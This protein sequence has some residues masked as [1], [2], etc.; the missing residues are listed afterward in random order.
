MS[1]VDCWS[2]S[3]CSYV[4]GLTHAKINHV[5]RFNRPYLHGFQVT[6]W[7]LILFL[8]KSS[9][10]VVFTSV[11]IS[12]DDT[13]IYKANK[14]ALF[15][16]LVQGWRLNRFPRQPV[17]MLDN[18]FSEE[19]FPNIQSKPPLAQLEAISSCPITCY[20]GEETDPTSLQPPSSQPSQFRLL[21]VQPVR[22]SVFMTPQNSPD[23]GLDL[24]KRHCSQEGS[25]GGTASRN[26]GNLLSTTLGII[27]RFTVVGAEQ[28]NVNKFTRPSALRTSQIKDSVSNR[29]RKQNRNPQRSHVAYA[30]QRNLIEIT[31]TPFADSVFVEPGLVLASIASFC[32]FSITWP[33]GKKVENSSAFTIPSPGT[34]VKEQTLMPALGSREPPIQEQRPCRQLTERGGSWCGEEEHTTG[35][36]QDEADSGA[37]VPR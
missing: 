11:A 35:G 32:V 12:S 2:R 26:L 4:A 5:F 23:P 17:P 6:D 18:P 24:A 31:G 22:D 20:L 1:W 3:L 9:C 27:R 7:S 10:V 15:S 14:R 37:C 19:K 33:S 36:R 16:P 8:L 34:D 25:R 28:K 29:I 21:D 13:V 30:T